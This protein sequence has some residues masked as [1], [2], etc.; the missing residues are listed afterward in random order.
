MRQGIQT[1]FRRP[2]VWIDVGIWTLILAVAAFL[3][4]AW[5][6]TIPPGMT[7]DEAA[8]GA[9]AEIIL[10]GA[11]P[12][13]FSLGYGHEPFYAYLV[14]AGFALF[15]HT[16]GVMRAV[17]AGF[18]LLLVLLT[19]FF[20][21]RRFGLPVAWIGT[22]WLAVAFWPI[23]MSRQALRGNMLAPLWLLAAILFWEAI[24]KA[25][26]DESQ[27]PSGELRAVSN[28]IHQP[29]TCNVLLSTFNLQLATLFTLSGLFLGLTFYTYLSARVTWVVFPAF[30]IYM[31]CF[32]EQ[33]LV[34]RRIWP[35]LLLMAVV[36]GLV[37][38]PLGLYLLRN[39]GEQVRLT[40]MM[41]PIN[42]F[43]AGRP[44]RLLG[45]FGNGL[46]VFSW[47]G[48]R[49]WAYNIAGRPIFDLFGSLAFYGGLLIAVWH[50]RD[51]RYAFLL[52]WL[53][54]S[55]F[56]GLVTTNEGIFLRILNAQPVVYLLAAL[57]PTF[58]LNQGIRYATTGKRQRLLRAAGL[59]LT[60]ALIF[61][62]GLRSFYDHFIDWPNQRETRTIYNQTIV[63][64]A[65]H[66][67]DDPQNGVV[68]FS[69]L[70]PLYYHDPWL[71]RYVAARPD[72][73]DRWFDGRG[74]V[75]YPH[76]GKARFVFSALTPLD[77]ALQ[78]D[79]EATATRV[80][81]YDLRPDD[82][83]PYFELWYWQ[84]REWLDARLNTLQ[85]DSPLWISPETQF[86]RPDL[87]R[88]LVGGATFG[89]VMTLMAY[90]LNQTT[91]EP[92]DQ[93]ELMTWW[94]AQ[95]T[96]YAQDDWDTFVHLLD[97]NG[98]LVGGTDVL[99]C[100]PTGWQP[101][102]VAVQVHRFQVGEMTPGQAFVE[103]GVYRHPAGR[104]PVVV[105]EQPVSDRVL[106][107]PVRIG[108]R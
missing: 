34:L 5:L 87:R 103:V 20:A 48:D 82:E 27:V 81:R 8:F 28:D 92:G 16:L 74:C 66:L 70:Y 19:C 6:D 84:D 42:E 46:R 93:I 14:A 2:G 107:K 78:A 64:A 39:P 102:D 12:V 67:R 15:G 49:F 24:E 65:Q 99:D 104:I 72:I 51:P 22:A 10:D 77:A 105:D 90:Q 40:G 1:F 106:L 69:A 11:R 76:E 83:N 101:G 79:F 36:A 98:Q 63:A 23:N 75:L 55:M 94:R 3:R 53:G 25:A 17:A 89:D 100:P 47:I 57:T 29:P 9:E 43:L 7:H 38:L 60:I 108:G 35:G 88:E 59:V 31:L 44:Q 86:T 41:E 50:W 56:P 18:G 62:E 91:F 30:V 97:Q 45:H 96:V 13:Y 58:L 26:R 73:S 54:A 4:F 68:A 85:A 32:K 52:L 37:A 80:A 33:R 21:R 95:R 61:N 71:F